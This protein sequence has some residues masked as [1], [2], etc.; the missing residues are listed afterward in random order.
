MTE[1]VETNIEANGGYAVIFTSLRSEGDDEAYTE[2]AKRMLAL[3]SQQPGFLGMDSVRGADGKGITVSYWKDRASI[4][5]WKH[6]TEHAE[7]RSKGRTHWYQHFTVRICKIEK[8][9]G[10]S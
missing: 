9:Y 4:D 7:A 3:V 5:A 8:E 6:H 10:F 1:D 2:T